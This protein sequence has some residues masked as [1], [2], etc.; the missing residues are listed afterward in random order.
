MLNYITSFS[1]RHIKVYD[2]YSDKIIF[3]NEN[4]F[5]IIA[6]SATFEIKKLKML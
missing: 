6:N 1:F 3:S 5:C 2:I 4:C